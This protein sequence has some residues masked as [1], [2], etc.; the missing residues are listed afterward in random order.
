MIVP[1]RG[2]T[3]DTVTR[4]VVGMLFTTAPIPQIVDHAFESSAA[5]RE[6]ATEV[7]TLSY[8]AYSI[9]DVRLV[10]TSRECICYKD[11]RSTAVYEIYGVHV[12]V[13]A[14]KMRA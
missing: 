12:A 8:S 7:R 3:R 6:A 11:L 5:P 14:W 4:S 2:W 10:A 1:R 13:T 9:H